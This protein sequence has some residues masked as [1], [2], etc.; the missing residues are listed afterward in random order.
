M[1]KNFQNLINNPTFL[2]TILFYDKSFWCTI[3]C[4]KML[5][6]AIRIQDPYINISNPGSVLSDRFGFGSNRSY[7]LGPNNG[8]GPFMKRLLHV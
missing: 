8:V 1:Y 6:Y 7:L 5:D 4:H 3:Q 2:H